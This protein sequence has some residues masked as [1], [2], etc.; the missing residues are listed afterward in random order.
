MFKSNHVNNQIS[1]IRAWATKGIPELIEKNP[2]MDDKEYFQKGRLCLNLLL[3]ETLIGAE[4]TQSDGKNGKG[5]Y[6]L[7]FNHRLPSKSDVADISAIMGEFIKNVENPF[8]EQFG[9]ADEDS[10]MGIP[11]ASLRL[12]K[13]NTKSMKDLIFGSG[14]TT[15]RMINAIDC[16]QLAAVGEQLR[17]KTI[18]NRVLI[19]GGIALVIT[20]GTAV[21]MNLYKKHKDKADDAGDD[22]PVVDID[23]DD[24]PEVNLDDSGDMPVVTID[25]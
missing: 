16:V 1:Q 7:K 18:R 15:N 19:V 5:D 2:G 13:V 25:E 9:A 14:C 21:G 11:T 3:I 22:T 17:K 4:F 23:A 12:E 10:N 24:M 6:K 8:M 20:G